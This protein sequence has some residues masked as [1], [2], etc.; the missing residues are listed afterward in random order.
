MKKNNFQL[1]NWAS[2]GWSTFKNNWILMAGGGAIYCSFYLIFNLLQ[3]IYL[4]REIVLFSKFIF[5]PVLIAGWWFFGLRIVREEPTS[6]THIFSGFSRFAKVWVTGLLMNI[7][8]LIGLFFLI[9]P[10]VVLLLTYELSLFIVMDKGLTPHEALS[11]SSKITSGYKYKL[12][13]LLLLRIAIGALAWPFGKGLYNIGAGNDKAFFYIAIGIVPYLICCLVLIPWFAATLATAYDALSKEYER[14][15][16][17]A[18][19]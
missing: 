6:F 12:F 2:N 5:L 4:G 7:V 18:T 1:M 9:I 16:R 3:H 14:S 15:H 19:V 11:L 8:V 10:G 17:E 13:G